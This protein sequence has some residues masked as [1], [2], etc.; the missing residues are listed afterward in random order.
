MSN[1]EK[2]IRDSL[3]PEGKLTCSEAYKISAK[4]GIDIYEIGKKAKELKIRISDCGLGQFGKLPKGEY[5]KEAYEKMLPFID[6]EIKL[7]AKRLEV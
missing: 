5:S 3:T 4:E 1:L 7:S 6:I 2:I